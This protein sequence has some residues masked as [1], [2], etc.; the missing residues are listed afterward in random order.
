[1]AVEFFEIVKVLYFAYI[2][3]LPYIVSLWPMTIM[4]EITR[5]NFK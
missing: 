2:T 4:P 1:M 5:V 3:C